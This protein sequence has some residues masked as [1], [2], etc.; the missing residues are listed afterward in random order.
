MVTRLFAWAAPAMDV[1]VLPDHTWVTSFDNTK[2]AYEDIEAV[3]SAGESFWYC[4]GDYR[5][6]GGT[7]VTATGKLGHAVANGDI[8]RCVALPNET[9]F[10]SQSARGTVFVYG[11]HG[12][13]HQL[14]NQILVATA[15]GDSAPL[16]VAEARG[17]WWS[18]F[19]FGAY[20]LPEDVWSAKR[21]SCSSS[22]EV[23]TSRQEP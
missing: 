19:R 7:P 18:S 16:T 22:L 1:D 2:F 11:R 10:A 23:A 12:V 15:S 20:G 17:Y 21:A 14:A 4:W 5:V 8:A 3:I 6:R 13:C 9:C